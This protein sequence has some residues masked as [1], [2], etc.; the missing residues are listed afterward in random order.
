MQLHSRHLEWCLLDLNQGHRDFQSRALPPEL[1][2]R[3]ILQLQ[4]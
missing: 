4:K 3:C 1:R 2:H